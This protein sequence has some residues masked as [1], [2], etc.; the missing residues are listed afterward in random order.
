M[1]T[2][3]SARALGGCWKPMVG[4]SSA[5]RPE[6][7]IVLRRGGSALSQ[8][9]HITQLQPAIADALAGASDVLDAYRRGVRAVV[10]ALGWRF[11]AA[12]EPDEHG[13]DVLRCVALWCGEDPGL[14]GF[15]ALT[16]SLA[17]R[18]GE[19]LPGRVWESV[20]PMWIT[21]FAVEA[22]MPRHRCAR[23]T[24]LHAAVC[25]PVLSERGLGGVLEL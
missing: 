8:G 12:W 11:G 19:G 17:L 22:A 4:L 10:V 9:G 7:G 24:G 6:P 5:K 16:R 1:T 20:Q 18:R 23:E 25:F 13:L 21:D 15:V 2:S 3:V 14:G